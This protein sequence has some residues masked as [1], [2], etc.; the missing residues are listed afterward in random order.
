MRGKVVGQ[1][2]PSVPLKPEKEI[3]IKSKQ[4]GAVEKQVPC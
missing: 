1:E 2:V 3:M 4:A